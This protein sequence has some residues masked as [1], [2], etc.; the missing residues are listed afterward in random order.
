M[1][2]V[3]IAELKN[4]LSTYLNDVKAGEEILVRD[5]RLPI[6]RIV[7]LHHDDDQDDELVALAAQGKVRL[8]EG[9]LDESFWKLP[10]PRV[11]PEVLL[12][13][14]EEERNED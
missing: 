13:A 9:P 11:S 1:K 5:R 3:N 2:I 6:A 14:L 7:P 8:G 10:A 12:S 4:R